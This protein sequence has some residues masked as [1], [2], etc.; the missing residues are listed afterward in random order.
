MNLAESNTR[1]PL[2][3]LEKLAHR[4]ARAKMRWYFH[5][6]VYVVV[7]LGLVTLAAS[8]GRHW[9]VFPLM[10]WGLGLLI[11]GA[12][13]WILAPGGGLY[14]RMLERERRALGAGNR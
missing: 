12:F 7:N 5:A 13:V 3:D 14:D 4:R 6:F 9:A 10:G 11:H 1:A 8:N 2:P